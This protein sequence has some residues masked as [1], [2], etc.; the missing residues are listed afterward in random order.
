MS[1]R[2][3]HIFIYMYIYTFYQDNNLSVAQNICVRAFDTFVKKNYKFLQFDAK[4]QYTR[5]CLFKFIL[6]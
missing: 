4:L 6:G 1:K 2:K 5:L 3:T